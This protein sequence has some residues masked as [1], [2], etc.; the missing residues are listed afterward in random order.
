MISKDLQRKEVG[1]ALKA[2]FDAFQFTKL[3]KV[4]EELSK[5]GV[6]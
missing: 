2:G 3:K 6:N 4:Q 1:A 5:R